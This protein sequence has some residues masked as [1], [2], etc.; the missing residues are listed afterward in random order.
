[1]NASV[2]YRKYKW[3]SLVAMAT[4][5]F[6]LYANTLHHGFVLDDY[7]VV[8]D[9]QSV[10]KGIGG[11]WEIWSHSHLFGYNGLNLNQYR[12][13][14]IAA[15]AIE[16][17]FFGMSAFAF[18]FIHVLLYAML[19]A[20]VLDLSF[21]TFP[22]KSPF[23]AIAIALLFTTHA[24]HTEVVANVKSSDEMYAMLFAIVSL[25][26]LLQY[27]NHKHKI[28]L[29][30]SLFMFLCGLFS[31]ENTVTLLAV[32][33][34]YLYFFCKQDLLTAARGSLIYLVPLA[35]YFIIRVSVLSRLPTV[36]AAEWEV[37][38]N[39]TLFGASTWVQALATNFGIFLKYIQLAFFPMTLVHDYSIG[40]FPIVDFTDVGALAG[41]LLLI[42]MLAIAG[43]L[44]ASR[45]LISFALL[46][47]L[48][49][50]SVTSNFVIKI[51]ATLGERFLFL[52]SYGIA[53]LLTS[54]LSSALKK[55][56]WKF[57]VPLFFIPVVLVVCIYAWK[58]VERNPDWKSGFALA[59]Q[60]VK[61]NPRSARIHEGLA[62]EYL[63]IVVADTLQ[64]AAARNALEHYT[65][66]L[67]YLPDSR[68]IYYHLGVANQ[69]LQKFPEALS[70][71]QKA[72]NAN[73][74]LKEADIYY[75][76]GLC[77][78]KMQKFPEAI[79]AYTSSAGI[80]PDSLKVW[81]RLSYAY[82][83]VEDYQN[84]I[85][86]LEK[87]NTIAQGQNIEYLTN[88]GVCCQI[89]QRNEEAKMYYTKVLALD[90]LNEKAKRNLGVLDAK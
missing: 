62:N 26:F 24:V 88:L 38:Y 28:Y 79:A 15:F 64:T 37:P 25:I 77:N 50:F 13:L 75:N 63:K 90:P 71:Y 31:K 9:N 30:L 41:L 84:A 87:C 76:M 55:L 10:H 43:M 81:S 42:I 6:L 68:D 89:L 47:F 8:V 86:V 54:L 17:Q 66:C 56:D 12:P 67:K 33:P 65:E 16:Y 36:T 21:L 22:K 69:Y 60:D 2:F 52:P 7:L 1:M 53:I 34:L 82:F 83:A 5:T 3:P 45:S 74:P 51:G 20:F 18:H 57:K 72:L 35:L 4:I 40:T 70:W 59:S 85:N 23:F 14:P 48:I 44:F 80:S 39:N 46:F 11:L 61:S 29:L 49:T 58:T 32:F 27:Q 73:E 19:C 78:D